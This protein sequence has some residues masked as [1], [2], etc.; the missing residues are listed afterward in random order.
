MFDQRPF[1]G[2]LGT[3]LGTVARRRQVGA[4]GEQV[5][6]N[7]AAEHP[8]ARSEQE[9]APVAVD[10]TE[11]LET[12]QCRVVEDFAETFDLQ[13]LVEAEAEHDPLPLADVERKRLDLA[14][15]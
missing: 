12:F 3:V 1:A 10:E 8:A 13:R 4:S 11:A 15:R 9:R 5:S 6:C 2:I 7:A 14:R